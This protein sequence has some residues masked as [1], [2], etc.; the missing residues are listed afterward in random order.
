LQTGT[1]DSAFGFHACD[2]A[3]GSE[4]QDTCLGDTA[5]I[6][7]GASRATVIGQAATAAY[8]SLV[9]GYSASDAGSNGTNVVIGY[10]AACTGSGEQ[11]NTI[12]GG[13]CSG[14]GTQYSLALGSHSVVAA[15]DATEINDSGATATN[16]TQHTLQY[17]SWNFLTSSGA[18]TFLTATITGAAPSVTTGQLG[19]GSS[20]VTTA[21]AGAA[22]LPANPL[23]FLTWNL[24]GTAVKVPYYSN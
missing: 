4:S 17:D 8:Q 5:N 18:A 7:A 1:Q 13:S 24:A 6:V 2:A 22:T 21:T 3:T 9:L 11:Y 10:Y 19:I 12:L 16:S 23:G 20:T 14:T 15:S